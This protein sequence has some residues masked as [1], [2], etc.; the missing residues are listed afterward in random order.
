MLKKIYVLIILIVLLIVL[1]FLFSVWQKNQVHLPTN[2]SYFHFTQGG[3]DYFSDISDLPSCENKKELFTT[4]PLKLTDFTTIDPLG[5]LSPSAHTFPAPHLYFRINRLGGFS[6]PVDKVPIVAPSD[7][8]IT[9][10]TIIKAQNRSDFKDDG[11]VKFG[12]CK[13]VKGYFDHI[14]DL[15]EKL[16]N[17]FDKAETIHCNEYTLTYNSGPIDWK[18]CTKKVNIDVKQGELIG[19][20]G[21]GQG[22]V[23]LDLALFDKRITPNNFAGSERIFRSELPYAVCPLDYFEQNISA[24]LKQRLGGYAS[25]SQSNNQIVSPACGEVVPD[26]EN[27]AKGYWFNPDVPTENAGHDP[28]HLFLGNDHI[29]QGLQAFSVGEKTEKSGPGLGLY[30]FEPQNSGFVNREFSEVKSDGQIYCYDT[31]N[32]YENN[33]PKT[34]LIQLEGA[35][36]LLIQGSDASCDSKPWTLTNPSRFIR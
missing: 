11:A 31:S 36:T 20:A 33:S 9:E 27:T 4:S 23:A 5:L 22:Q 34:I 21:G 7:I 16:Q 25:L 6:G 15:P 35:E 2:D 32:N 12:V 8:T 30:Y 26:I 28:P 14:V 13:E 3:Y 29:S 19:F 17:A 18:I 1:V 24:S 10:M